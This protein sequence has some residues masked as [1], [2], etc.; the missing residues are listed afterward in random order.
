MV[1]ETHQNEYATPPS[2]YR[3]G[4]L[5]LCLATAA[6]TLP[7]MWMAIGKFGGFA[8]GMFGFELIVLFGCVM[9]MLVALSKVK[10]ASAFPLALICLAGTILVGAVFGLYVDARAV[11]GDNPTIQP[12]I[13]R[14]IMARLLVIVALVLI[15]TLE[16]YRRDNR[17]WGMVFK[18]VLFF[19]PVLVVLAWIR[20]K[21]FPSLSNS[22]GDLLPFRMVLMLL[23]GLILGIFMSIG[24]HF[25]IRSF[26]IAVPD[27]KSS[28]NINS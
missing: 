6:T 18:A 14:T 27:E 7:W 21:G 13:N 10:V 28:N 12:W 19:F 8:W 23:G 15:S 1:T 20:F 3:L 9:T 2:F 16:M 11:I 4:T 25:L 5:V 24:G 17:S 26:E 22:A